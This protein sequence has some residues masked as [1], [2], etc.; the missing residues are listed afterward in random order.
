MRGRPKGQPKTGGRKKGSV[1]K[2]TR[3]IAAKGRLRVDISP[4]DFMLNVM[5]GTAIPKRAPAAVKA[6]LIALQFDAAKAAAPYVHARLGAI[7]V[8]PAPSGES[9][10]NAAA[11]VNQIDTESRSLLEVGR[12][13]AFT[14]ALAAQET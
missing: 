8:Q 13:I 12:R 7:V 4:L 6:Q 3:L 2:K 1:N 9:I 11:E 10:S 14:L 5:R